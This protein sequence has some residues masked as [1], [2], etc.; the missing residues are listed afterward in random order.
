V[1]HTRLELRVGER[2]RRG[3][4]HGLGG[5]SPAEFAR[6]RRDSLAIARQSLDQRRH[7]A[8]CRVGR[9]HGHEASDGSETTGRSRSTVLLVQ[10]E[11]QSS[12]AAETE[13]IYHLGAVVNVL[14][15]YQKL[16]AA[17]VG[18][19]REILRLAST[20]APKRVHCVSPA[21]L[22]QYRDPALAGAEH[23]LGEDPPRLGNGYVQS[24]WVA[25]RIAALALQRG[26]P[27]TIYRAARLIGS[28]QCPYWK[29]GD[30]VSE[31]TRAC[32]QLGVVPTVDAGMPVSP[33]DYVAAAMAWLSRQHSTAGG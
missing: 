5:L 13:A 29:L 3:E 17:N 31:L 16:R 27:V 7:A 8:R 25:E 30:V 4:A 33:V 6:Q 11:Y 14:P 9:R 2:Q 28:P 26:V 22:T 24:K 15:P 18:A 12:S 20:G 21:E 23:A 19:V 32:V 1:R 10:G